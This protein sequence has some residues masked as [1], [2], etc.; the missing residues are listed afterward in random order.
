MT[1][2]RLLRWLFIHCLLALMPIITS[3]VVYSW[4]NP[5][6]ADWHLSVGEVLFFT[7]MISAIA[8]GDAGELVIELAR[9]REP[10]KSLLVVSI[11]L[12]VGVLYTLL[13]YGLNVL[14]NI[15]GSREVS[16]SEA[17]LN[18]SLVL[19]VVFFVLGTL[20]QVK[21]SQVEERWRRHS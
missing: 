12:S 9:F 14:H 7:F 8:L 2:I 19:A 18:H 5:D 4:F 16:G 20:V 17:L 3:Y 1:S 15:P 11:M 6:G 10:Y 13:L 21:F